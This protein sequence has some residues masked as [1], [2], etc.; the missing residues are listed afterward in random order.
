MVICGVEFTLDRAKAAVVAKL[1]DQIDAGVGLLP[2]A[3]LGPFTEGPSI[4]ILLS[5]LGIMLEELDAQPLEVGALL[6]LGLGSGA[7]A[8]KQITNRTGH[9]FSS[10]RKPRM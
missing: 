5:H 8:L 9:Y 10:R 6:T 2:P 7:V 4:L 3:G 1:G